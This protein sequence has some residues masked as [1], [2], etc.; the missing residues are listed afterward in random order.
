MAKKNKPAK[1]DVEVGKSHF[2]IGKSQLKTGKSRI[3]FATAP[4]MHC[5]RAVNP[6]HD[7]ERIMNK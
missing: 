3:R 2:E 1:A 5:R 6:E 4:Q 7:Y